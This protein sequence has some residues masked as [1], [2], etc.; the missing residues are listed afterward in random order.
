MIIFRYLAKEILISM[1]AVSGVLLL[2]IMSG[3]F[4]KYLVEAAAG[5]FSVDVLFQIMAYRLP[6]FL[7]LILPLGLFLAILLAY[8]RLYL[9]SE[10]VV[11]KATG[12]SERRLAMYTLGPGLLVALLVGSLSLFVTP[13]GVNQTALL[14]KKQE[15]ASEFDTLAA[16]R[17]QR[18][19]N[20]LRVTYTETISDGNKELNNIFIS[21]RI[22][23]G[24]GWQLVVITAERGHQYRDPE[25][26]ARFLILQEGYRYEG[27]PGTAN[28]REIQFEQYGV[29]M[30]EKKISEGNTAIEALSTKLLLNE[31][32]PPHLAQLH[33]R[34]SLPVLALIV[35][36][37]AVPLSK[38][39]PR[40]GR[41]AKLVPAILIYLAY[42]VLL[43]NARNLVAGGKAQVMMI[44]GVH[45]AFFVLA[46]YL[47]LA[48]KV[49]RLPGRKRAAVVTQGGGDA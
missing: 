12:M 2:I 48:K 20:S 11:L 43:T 14:L 37:L 3:R 4:I 23:S 30:P 19:G 44:W 36:L 7:E 21:D 26:G 27:T 22:K 33:W 38:T 28:Y 15:A 18:P 25:S 24:G 40:Q 10:M 31:D 6:G 8:G 47:L 17:F 45:A 29:R 34:L 39:E 35:A 41:F 9:E 42:L 49:W 32:Q 13:Y 16:G 46:L 5:R 1:T